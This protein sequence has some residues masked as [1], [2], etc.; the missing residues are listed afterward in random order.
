ME[1]ILDWLNENEVRAYPLLDENRKDFQFESSVWDLPDN[2]IL[3]LQL[4]VKGSML[5]DYIPVLNKLV[6]V[7]GSVAVHFSLMHGTTETLEDLAVFN[8]SEAAT[9]EYPYYVRNA[10][11]DLA[12]FGKGVQTLLGAYLD[13]VILDAVSPIP[14]EPATAVQFDDAWLGV[15]SITAEPEKQTEQLSYE[16]TKPLEDVYDY[17]AAITEQ[18]HPTSLVGHVKFLE[19]YNFRVDI[20]SEAIDLEIGARFGLRMNCETSFIPEQY[21]DCDELVSYING[22]P[23]DNNGSFRLLAGTSI[24]ITP[25]TAVTTSFI[26][27]LTETSNNNTLFVGLS[28]QTTDLCDPVNITPS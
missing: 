23:P 28:F 24:N 9:R 15:S 25:G 11:G 5:E 27:S 7:N 2:F 17:L 16:P 18:N 3:D 22:V 19:G 26:D 4:V 20:A 21:L 12:V 13:G 14:T 6:V 1:Q 10:N 8:I